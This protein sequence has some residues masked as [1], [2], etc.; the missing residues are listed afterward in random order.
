MDLKTCGDQKMIDGP[1]IMHDHAFVFTILVIISRS[2]E[3]TLACK[4]GR[5]ATVR[6]RCNPAVAAKDLITLPRYLSP[7]PHSTFSLFQANQIR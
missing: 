7:R 5:S 2:S 3:T 4:E 6:L 1:F